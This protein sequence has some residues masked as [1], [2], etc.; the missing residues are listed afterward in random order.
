MSALIGGKQQVFDYL[1][2]I[3][4]VERLGFLGRVVY[5]YLFMTSRVT[6]KTKENN[7]RMENSD[8]PSIGSIVRSPVIPIRAER[9]SLFFLFPA[10]HQNGISSHTK[11]CG[12]CIVRRRRSATAAQIMAMLYSRVLAR[13]GR[14]GR[15]VQEDQEDLPLRI[16]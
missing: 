10:A 4:F 3:L 5:Y 12:R 7:F 9:V 13:L 11:S 14:H 15:R 1:N 6:V 2:R 8:V 16:L